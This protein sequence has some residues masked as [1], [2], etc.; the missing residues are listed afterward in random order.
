MTRTKRTVTFADLRDGDQLVDKNGV[1]WDVS[2]VFPDPKVIS[3]VVTHPVD[4]AKVFKIIKVPTDPA[5]IIRD[6][7]YAA[8]FV[9]GDGS[10]SHG[11]DARAKIAEATTQHDAAVEAAQKGLGASVVTEVTAEEQKAADDATEAAPKIDKA[12]ED[13]TDLEQRSHG[14]AVH[15]IW[16]KDSMTRKQR[17]AEHA[18]WHAGRIPADLRS[19]LKPHVHNEPEGKK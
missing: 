17:I 13:M 5:T 4:S 16:P 1:I 9:D 15:G 11:T 19:K 8:T 14:F 3:Y 18:D 6:W 7:D 2:R 12:F 10:V